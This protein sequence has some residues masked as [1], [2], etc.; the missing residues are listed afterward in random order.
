MEH[1]VIVTGRPDALLEEKALELGAEEYVDQAPTPPRACAGRCCGRWGPPPS[2]SGRTP[3]RRR[4]AGLPDGPSEPAGLHRRRGRAAGGGPPLAVCLF[5][6]DDLKKTN[7]TFGHVE[8]D[9]LI[10]EFG[11]LLR[12]H[13]RE[14]DIL[15][16]Y[17]GDEFVVVMRQVRSEE[18]ALKKGGE[19]CLAARKICA[20]K[21]AAAA[22]TGGGSCSASRRSR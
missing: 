13:T 6:L 17:G 2:R 18:A 12:A 7:D 20:P 16:R 19:I 8:G 14:N 1:A 3:C 4:P 5:D 11:A 22:C 9:R 15:S 21:G 10:E